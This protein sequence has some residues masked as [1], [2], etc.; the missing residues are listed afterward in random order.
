[1]SLSNLP[2]AVAADAAGLVAEGPAAHALWRRAYAGDRNQPSRVVV[3]GY[4]DALVSAGDLAEARQVLA[5][6][7]Q[8]TPR[9]QRRSLLERWI[10]LGRM[11]GDLSEVEA[12]LAQWADPDAAVLLAGLQSE[13]GDEDAA[14]A[15]LRQAW[16]QDTGHRG[17]Q[18]ALMKQLVRAGERAELAQLVAAVVRMSPRDPMPWLTLLDADVAARD[19]AAVRQRTDEL[20]QRFGRH[21][22]LL[23]ALIDRAQRIGDS[24]DRIAAL[25]GKLLAAA[26]GA[27]EQAQAYAE[28][29]LD[30]GRVEIGRAHV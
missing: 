8:R 23:E 5:A 6:A 19:H 24:P 10:V 18:A 3:E 7:L 13:R 22:A 9:G 4:V 30:Q 26:Q 11:A 16:R 27:P 14:M 20:A 2:A 12:R 25:Y 17:V 15:T 29:L 28:W 21:V 1:M